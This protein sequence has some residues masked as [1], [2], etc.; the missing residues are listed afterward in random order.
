M[1]KILPII[2]LVL[3]L[4]TLLGGCITTNRVKIDS[5][6][7][8]MNMKKAFVVKQDR[9]AGNVA[10]HISDYLMNKGYEVSSGLYSS[11]P[12]DTDFYVTYTERWNREV[13]P[14][15]CSLEIYF[16][17]NKTGERIA[18]GSYERKYFDGIKSSKKITEIVLD[19]IFL[20]R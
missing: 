18:N 5:K 9:T 11:K 13:I 15:F 4:P 7:D 12:G 6:F 8:M 3:L 17:D 16:I 19:S 1:I 14:F 2:C 10:I 20:K